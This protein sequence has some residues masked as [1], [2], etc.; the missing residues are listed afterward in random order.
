MSIPP[1]TS[2]PT[3]RPLS[4]RST[5]V[6]PA[7]V[8]TRHSKR[9]QTRYLSVS[10]ISPY[11]SYE[12]ARQPLTTMA[13][14]TFRLCWS[15]LQSDSPL[16]LPS[17]F[18]EQHGPVRRDAHTLETTPSSSPHRSIRAYAHREKGPSANDVSFLPG[19]GGGDVFFSF[20][21]QP[22]RPVERDDSSA[23]SR[24]TWANHGLRP[25]RCIQ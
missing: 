9:L 10:P 8:G 1:Q 7:S 23:S 2:N 12:S 21:A 13:L 11:Q 19:K 24:R 16:N 20:F 25:V 22:H 17:G 3:C 15:L 4:R 5:V 14:Q 18:P 6:L